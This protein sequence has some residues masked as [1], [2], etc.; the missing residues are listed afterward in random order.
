[1]EL[2]GFWDRALGTG[3]GLD[4]YEDVLSLAFKAA[5]GYT[6]QHQFALWNESAKDLNETE[7]LQAEKEDEQRTP[8][9]VIPDENIQ[10]A[11]KEDEP[12]IQEEKSAPEKQPKKKLPQ[13]LERINEGGIFCKY[14]GEWFASAKDVRRHRNAVHYRT[15][16]CRLCNFASHADSL[17][18]LHYKSRHTN[19]RDQVRL[20]IL[21]S[22]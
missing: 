1:M 8:A 10:T 16:K 20:S 15:K 14:C 7:A 6:Q 12:S 2:T 9:A 3:S 18:D 22:T 17:L 11:E 13:H 19:I 4:D 5:A 21:H